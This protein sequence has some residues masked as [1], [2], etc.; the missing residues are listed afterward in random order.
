MEITACE[1]RETPNDQWGNERGAGHAAN[2]PFL[3]TKKSIFDK[4]SLARAL[5]AEYGL[6]PTIDVNLY[7]ISGS[8]V[9]QV[10]DHG[11]S[12]WFLK[13]YRSTKYDARRA[14][15]SARALQVLGR[16]GFS[17]PQLVPNQRGETLVEFRAVEG[18]RIAYMY[19]GI[20]GPEPREA[21]AEHGVRFGRTAARLHQVMDE[22]ASP[23]DFSVVDYDYLF[24]RYLRGVEHFLE[25]ETSAL[26]FLRKLAQDLWNELN[27]LLPKTS[28]QFGFCHGDMHT[29]N[30]VLTDA[31]QIFLLDFDACGFGWRVMDIGTYYVSHDWM[32][33]DDEGYRKRQQVCSYFLQG[34]NSVRPL[35]EEELK[36]LDL[37]MAIRHFELLGIGIYRVPFSGMHWVNREQLQAD[38]AWFRTWLQGHEW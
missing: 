34:Y 8:D 29:G 7:R 25:Y 27:R 20:L 38:V 2:G 33:L 21:D 4:E 9:Y 5:Q 24:G 26:R 12:M 31:G 17:V 28:P 19:Q 16:H 35:T 1:D 22:V 30:A 3:R 36:A 32:G 23:G 37:F 15:A 13:V 11:D 6:P 18:P 10:T 14:L